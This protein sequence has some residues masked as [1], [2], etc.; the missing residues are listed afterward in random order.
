MGH[1]F[2][3]VVMSVTGTEVPELPEEL[4]EEFAP[5]EEEFGFCGGDE[6]EYSSLDEALNLAYSGDWEEAHEL[7]ASALRNGEVDESAKGFALA[8][9][10]DIQLH[11]GRYAAASRNFRRAAELTE[12]GE[13]LQAESG[14]VTALYKARRPRE[15]HRQA[16]AFLNAECVGDAG[17]ELPLACYG[18]YHVQARTTAD[19][20]EM[21]QAMYSAEQIRLAAPSDDTSYNDLLALLDGA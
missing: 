16:S 3:V 21:F 13:R 14:A 20:Q 9:L 19:A 18:M 1:L 4:P 8:A 2:V 12:D 5:D 11:I 15:A 17:S 6:G 7:L 10:G